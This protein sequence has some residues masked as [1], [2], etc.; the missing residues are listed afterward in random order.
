MRQIVK[1]SVI[2]LGATLF[3]ACQKE[4]NE[5]GAQLIVNESMKVLSIE[6]SDIKASLVREPSLAALNQ[7]ETYIGAIQDEGFGLTEA[8]FYTELALSSSGLDMGTSAT[9]DSL[10]L[11]LDIEGY[12]GS[13]ATTFDFKVYEM[14]ETIEADAT[15]S[16]TTPSA[17]DDFQYY[18]QAVAEETITLDPASDSILRI[19]FSNTF[20]QRFIESG[21]TSFVDNEAFQSFLNGFYVSAES[22]ANQEGLLVNLDLSSDQSKLVL[23]YHTDEED[24]LVYKFN[25]GN[26]IDRVNRWHHDYSG[27]ELETLL[28]Q[29]EVSKACVQGGAGIRTHIELE[30][31]AS[32]KDANYT[33]HQAELV[34]PYIA[35][36]NGEFP[37]PAQLG[38][39]AITQNGTLEALTADQTVQG[40]TYFGGLKDELSQTYRFNIIRYVHDVLHEGYTNTLA[41]RVP[42]SVKQPGGVFI[43]HFANADTTGIRLHLLVSEE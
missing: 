23:F 6:Q 22:T 20:A 14:S 33:I 40:A 16:G 28:V 30:G 24:S 1:L 13:T 3:S 12:Y 37:A 25:L 5:L 7:S 4:S 29:E 41:L 11:E 15:E 9:L 19:G 8:S 38:L 31:L 32:L 18:N 27:T 35:G 36:A 42:S 43:N 10:V 34:V 2:A 21:T 17:S 26:S 39:S